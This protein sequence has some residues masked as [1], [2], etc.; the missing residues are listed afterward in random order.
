MAK[1]ILLIDDDDSFREVLR[2]HLAEEGYDVE[3]ASD[4]KQ[5][6]GLFQEKLHS[7][8]LTDLKMPEMDGLTLLKEVLK[9]SPGTAV[10]VITAFGDIETAVRAMK[11]GAFDFIPK[12]T[13]REHFKLV[14]Q[15]AFE[16]I[17]LKA[18]L[19][20]LEGR[21]PSKSGELVY[22]SA[23]MERVVDL[24][25][26]VAPSNST[27]LLR[28][29]SGTGKEILARR[30]HFRSERS[31]GPF[32]PVNCAAMPK[33]LLESELFGHVKGA[34]TG[35]TRDHKGKFQQASG[36]TIFL[37]EIGELP[38]E[39]QPRLLRVLQE[40]TVDLVGGEKPIG[41]DVRVIA[42]TNRDIEKAVSQ[43]IFRE[44]L[45]FRL[46]VVPIVIPPLRLRKED[47]ALLAGHF[48]AMHG[49][50]GK[51]RFTKE[52]I[53]K[54]ES[55]AWPGNVR[56]LDN[57]CQRLVL[58]ADGEELNAAQLPDFLISGSGGDAAESANTVE[59]DG[60]IQ[61]VISSAGASLDDLQKQIIA[62]A[63]KKNGYN[64]SKTARFLQIPRHVLLYRIEKY[65]IPIDK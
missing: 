40:H 9:R 46:N 61:L 30:I 32:V 1:S 39:L 44:D 28:G 42:A 51:H 15:R 37:D 53:E 50:G 31:N 19:R 41:V 17:E 4:G 34:F 45:Y 65:K 7:V 27:V 58:L 55:Y 35:A 48:V 57:V 56:E 2:F 20:E 54:L 10:I 59:G 33:D 47:I 6:L 25:Q 22:Q 11:A 26:R 23:A 36:G 12:P 18:R 16:H 62:A 52:L 43:G 49:R 64:Q 3:V 24:A 60:D 5:G 38:A 63:L 13:S 8:V 14:V 29:E 21:K